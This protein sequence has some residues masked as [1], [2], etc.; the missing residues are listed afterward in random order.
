VKGVEACFEAGIEVNLR[1]NLDSHNLGSLEELMELVEQRGW[2]ARSGFQCQL[3][4]V[5]DHLGTSTYS[6]MMRE[7]ALVEPVLE[8][9]RQRPELLSV[10]NFQLF[11]V[12][13]HLISTI[14]QNAKSPTLPRFHYCEGDRGDVLTFGPDGLIYVC[15]ESVG[16]ARNAVGRYSPSY[17]L[18]PRRMQRWE[19]RS[20]LA[21][22]ECRECSIATFC[23][24]GCAYAALRQFGSP[25]HGVCG[26]TPE[27]V[28][29]YIRMLRRRFENGE[30][31]LFASPAG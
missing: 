10:L 11:R 23:G 13:Q 16:D 5:T 21:L 4:P 27:V 6:P 31:T 8:F 29:A 19:N 1:V 15:T 18:S 30:G 2:A 3:A 14:E 24:G 7:D 9:Q 17:R 25:A 22:E 26:D 20:V 12:L 28:A